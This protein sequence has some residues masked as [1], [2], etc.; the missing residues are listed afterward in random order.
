[1][2]VAVLVI[3]GCVWLHFCSSKFQLIAVGLR[4]RKEEE[5]SSLVLMVEMDD[6]TGR[7]LWSWLNH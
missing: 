2:G 1:M 6:F 5:Y 4:N 3:F 7:E